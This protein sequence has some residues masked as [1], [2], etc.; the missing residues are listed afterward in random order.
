MET[1]FHPVTGKV[2]RISELDDASAFIDDRL[3][4]PQ[5]WITFL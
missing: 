5:E 2:I 3:Y 4:K 1:F